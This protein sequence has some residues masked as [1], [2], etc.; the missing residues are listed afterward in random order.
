MLYTF[1]IIKS[2]VGTSKGGRGQFAYQPQ[3]LVLITRATHTDKACQTPVRDG[4]CDGVLTTHAHFSR[5]RLTLPSGGAGAGAFGNQ[6]RTSFRNSSRNQYRKGKIIYFYKICSF[7]YLQTKI[8]TSPKL[9]VKL[10]FGSIKL[11]YFDPYYIA[12]FE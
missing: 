1:H 6:L 11:F 3:S 5:S 8:L 12:Y 10:F 2:L 7:I 4:V 9:F